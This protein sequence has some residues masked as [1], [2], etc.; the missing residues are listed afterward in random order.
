[1]YMDE[2]RKMS[3]D[4]KELDFLPLTSRRLDI[5]EE[6]KTAFSRMLSSR[7]YDFIKRCMLIWSKFYYNSMSIRFNMMD[8]TDTD[9][10]LLAC[11]EHLSEDVSDIG[12]DLAIIGYLATNWLGHFIETINKE[13]NAKNVMACSVNELLESSESSRSI[14]KQFYDLFLVKYDTGHGYP[15]NFIFHCLAMLKYDEER[16]H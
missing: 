14:P 7:Q 12:F 4:T 2:S 13:L 8:M 16:L 3:F 10:M 6:S 11:A 5:I 15:K 1:M 9:S